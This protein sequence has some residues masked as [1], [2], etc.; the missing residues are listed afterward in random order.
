MLG[1]R[2]IAGCG[3]LIQ[4]S[5]CF[6]V[7]LACL[8]LAGC[9]RPVPQSTS[10]PAASDPEIVA[11][12]GMATITRSDV[13]R[14]LARSAPGRSRAEALDTLIQ[15][16]AALHKAKREGY[17]REPGVVAAIERLVV[18][19]YREAQ[20]A[21]LIDTAPIVSETDLAAAYCEQVPQWLV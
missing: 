18:D 13:E 20:R 1:A 3:R 11:R 9:D 17:D 6:V 4:S 2:A 16:Q 8:A 14:E 12:V 5:C 10:L 7:G 15:F 21:R 19:R